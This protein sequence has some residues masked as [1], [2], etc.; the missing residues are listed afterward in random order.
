MKRFPALFVIVFVSS[1]A[2]SAHPFHTRSSVVYHFDLLSGSHAIN[3]VGLDERGIKEV[4]PNEY[5]VRYQRWK[6]ELLA[7]KYGLTLWDSYSTNLEFI[8][9][10]KV[11]GSRKFGAGTDDFEWDE[12]GKLIA[13]TITLG[14]DL[15]KGF[16]DPIYYPV[17]NSLSMNEESNGIDGSVLASTKLAHEIGHVNFTAEANSR[18]F[19]RQ[20]RLIAAYYK[21]FLNNGYNTRDPRLV[22]L[23]NELGREPIEIWEDREY[24]SE[25]SAMKFLVQ[26]IRK[27]TYYCS[28]LNK[29]RRNINNFAHNYRDRFLQFSDI[30]ESGACSD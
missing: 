9:T 28:V 16:P 3:P 24:W 10:I 12:N 19:Q 26:R 11:S 23:S 30:A 14:K 7:T 4:V 13:A 6:D 17:M 22:E 18:I 8:L 21:I 27:E 20:D 15:D 29:V 25:V 5:R 1:A 2:L